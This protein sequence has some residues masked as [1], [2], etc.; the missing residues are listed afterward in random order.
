MNPTDKIKVKC[1]GIFP[2]ATYFSVILYGTVNLRRSTMF[3]WG[4]N[5]SDAPWYTENDSNPVRL[6]SE[7]KKYLN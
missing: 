2:Q 7:N 6:P 5:S 3:T 4:S 1:F